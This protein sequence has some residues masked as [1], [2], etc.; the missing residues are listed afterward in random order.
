[1]YVNIDEFKSK[2]QLLCERYDPGYHVKHVLNGEN[3]FWV[4]TAVTASVPQMILYITKSNCNVENTMSI[5]P[6]YN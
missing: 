3:T 1:M 6:C 4:T 5:F 2:F